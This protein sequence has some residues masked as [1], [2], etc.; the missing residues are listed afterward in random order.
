MESALGFVLL[1]QILSG[2]PVR[3]AVFESLSYFRNNGDYE[4]IQNERE[5]MSFNGKLSAFSPIIDLL[6]DS[7]A[8]RTYV[9][10][11]YCP[12]LIGTVYDADDPHP[13]EIKVYL[14]SD[15]DMKETGFEKALRNSYENETE[16]RD[17]IKFLYAPGEHIFK[18]MEIKHI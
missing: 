1:D 6:V 8:Y 11:V 18:S 2:K 16:M 4:A 10:K 15:I 17:F 14:P 3:D 13:M 7:P 12:D 5:L 9:F